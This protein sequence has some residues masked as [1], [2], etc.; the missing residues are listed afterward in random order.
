MLEDTIFIARAKAARAWSAAVI[1]NEMDISGAASAAA[2]AVYA[3]GKF[4]AT[5]VDKA[6]AAGALGGWLSFLSTLSIPPFPAALRAIDGGF[7]RQSLVTRLPAI[8]T[9]TLLSSGASSTLINDV[10]ISLI[11][12]LLKGELLP[13]PLFGKL[14]FYRSGTD[15]SPHDWFWQENVTYD[16]LLRIYVEHGIAADP[17][18]S[19]KE[20]ALAAAEISF[21]TFVAPLAN[22]A[23]PPDIAAALLASLWGNR[24]DLSLSAGRVDDATA[25]TLPGTQENRSL[26]P[27]DALLIDER[28]NAITILSQQAAAAIVLI[29]DNCGAELLADL[30]LSDALL[31]K[32]AASV[33]LHA[34]VSPTFVSDA[35]CR[36][37]WNTVDWLTARIPAL[38]TR[39]RAASAAGTFIVESHPFWNAPRAGW[40]MPKDLYDRLE[41][42]CDLAIFK[43]DANYRRL[44]GDRHWPHDTPFQSVVGAY[45]PCPLLA[46]RT[47]KAGLIVGVSQEL[48]SRARAIHEGRD[49]GGI[50]ASDEWLV[51]GYFG[52]AQFASVALKC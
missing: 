7:T 39:L 32:G 36:D 38:A 49:G 18:A 10:K 45:T 29:L 12:P 51:T 24:G 44:L 16:H 52:V 30:V 15:D 19:Q 37:V 1:V 9:E 5:L 46:L 43:G 8:L 28:I 34:K 20:R 25:L 11:D 17:F 33:T 47:C 3:T 2:V 21:L 4:D 27:D 23:N 13:S 14:N 41:K 42:T 22:D 26:L 6:S 35:T 48:E 31:R 40:E 50:D